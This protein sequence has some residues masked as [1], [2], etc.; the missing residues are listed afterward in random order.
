MSSPSRIVACAF[1]LIAIALP[2]A[3]VTPAAAATVTVMTYNTKHGGQKTSPAT[4]D[5]QI[6]TIVAQNPDVVVLQEAD[7]SQLSYYVNRLNAG[8]GTT[9]W[10][11]AYARHCQAGAAPSCT[12]YSTETVM[13]LTR[14][15]TKA[16]DSILVWAKD[17]YHVARATLHHVGH[18]L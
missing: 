13:I 7:M 8:L 10:H 3:I 12:S 14:L 18:I 4:T 6:A 11:G 15:V 9:A 1:R 16:T 2:L 5:G 17:D